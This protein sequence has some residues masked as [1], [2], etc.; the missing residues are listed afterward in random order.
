MKAAAEPKPRPAVGHFLDGQ[1]ALPQDLHGVLDS[2]AQHVFL[3][4]H[5]FFMAAMPTVG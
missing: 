2:L 3:R 5:A 1:V 4:P